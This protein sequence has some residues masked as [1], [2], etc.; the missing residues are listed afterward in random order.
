MRVDQ[1]KK[2]FFYYQYITLKVNLHL[3][4]NISLRSFLS[5]VDRKILRELSSNSEYYLY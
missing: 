2:L 4:Q 1:S 3:K 5:I